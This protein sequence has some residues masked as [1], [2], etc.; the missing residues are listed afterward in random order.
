MRLG[1]Q[2]GEQDLLQLFLSERD[3]LTAELE[4][5]DALEQALD[6]QADLETLMLSGK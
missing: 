4:Y 3:R 5:L 6:V 1:V 2:A